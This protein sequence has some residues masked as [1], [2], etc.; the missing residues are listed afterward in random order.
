MRSEAIERA[1][2]GRVW[3]EDGFIKN[4]STLFGDW[5]VRIADLRLIGEATN[6]NGPFLD[7]WMLIFACDARAWFEASVFAP[8]IF[9]LCEELG[10]VVGGKLVPQ[11]A[12]SATFN[13]RVM[14]PAALQ[15]KPVFR[16]EDPPAKGVIG[17]ALRRLFKPASNVQRFSDEVLRFLHDAA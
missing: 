7:D 11:L 3:I 10:G 16:Y 17:R 4:R 8:G 12:G 15:G 1:M 13:S 5:E 2:T 14:W 9:E 6:E